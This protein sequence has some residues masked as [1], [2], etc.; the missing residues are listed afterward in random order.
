MNYF[1]LIKILFLANMSHT[2][3]TMIQKNNILAWVFALLPINV[4]LW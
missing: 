4:L 2:D 3:N 1:D